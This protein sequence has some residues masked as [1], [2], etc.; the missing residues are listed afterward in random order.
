MYWEMMITM[1]E[2]SKARNLPNEERNTLWEEGRVMRKAKQI[3]ERKQHPAWGS[4]TARNQRRSVNENVEHV[5]G[6]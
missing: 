6:M 3:G 4:S 5:M 2:L 1:Q